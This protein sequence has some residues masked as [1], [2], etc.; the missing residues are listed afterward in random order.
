MHVHTTK[1]KNS[2]QFYI[3]ES[4][5][6]IDGKTNT[7]TVEKLGNLEEVTIKAN[8]MDPYEWA[9]NRAKTLTE[10]AN[11]IN[12][13][14]SVSFSPSKLIPI[15]DPQVFDGG[16]LP[17]QSLYYQLRIDEI[18]KNIIDDSKIEYDLNNI[19]SM[20]VYE[21][22]INPSSKRSSYEFS[23][24]LLQKRNFDLHHVYKSL[25]L[26]SKNNEKIQESLY[27]NSSKII[28]RNSTV[29]YYDCT[30]FY[31]ETESD[32]NLRKYGRSKEHRPNPIVQ[33]GLFLDGNGLPLAFDLTPGNTN[34]QTTLKPIEKRIIR[35]FN[36]SEVIVC[37]DA[38][39]S[40]LA[41]RKFNN[42]TNR[43][44][45]TVQPLKKLKGHLREWALD[46]SGF[47]SQK[48]KNIDIKDITDD[49]IYY[50][51][52]WINE[53]G[54]EERLIISYSS[55]YNRF[56]KSIREK[57]IERAIKKIDKNEDIFKSNNPNNPNRFITENNV[58]DDGEIA[59]IQILSLNQ[60]QIDKEAQY[61]GFYGI[62][63]NLEI[64]IEE[65]IKINK[66]R[67]EIEETFRIMKTDFKAR[68]V[69]VSTE[70]NIQAHF[71][72]C[73]I[74]LLIL[75]IL[76]NKLD[77]KYTTNEIIKTLRNMKYKYIRG[78]GYIPSFNTSELSYELDTI[79]KTSLNNEIISIDMMKKNKRIT[80]NRK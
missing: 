57:Q 75:R 19:L 33:M 59:D 48:I 12:K 25:K 63:T 53:N 68:P 26:L 14:I 72:T 77:N 58:T 15:G 62:S 55:R 45:I 67:W 13:D 20:L 21:R 44:Y 60:D 9:K 64:A 32:G 16:Y 6:T 41:N 65:I 39:L 78:I 2:I 37:T 51:E 43:S 56:Q 42:T 38:G 35:D 17:L 18:A 52:R 30:N 66:G 4:F 49:D 22:I 61:D 36:K 24:S 54:L 34:E 7:R 29:L 71:L 79:F 11:L 31:F 80:K 10:E 40:S 27:K 69:F 74:A 70:E 3:R 5:R 47:S 8:G 1:S 76:E 73:F 46:T 28:D 50:K 23:K